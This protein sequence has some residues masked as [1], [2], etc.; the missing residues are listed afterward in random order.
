MGG[1]NSHSRAIREHG[2]GVR[3]R[4]KARWW[5]SIFHRPRWRDNIAGRYSK[6]S[7]IGVASVPRS[8]QFS[9][10][11]PTLR[12]HVTHTKCLSRAVALAFLTCFQVA[13]RSR[14]LSRRAFDDCQIAVPK[15]I[16]LKNRRSI[17]PCGSFP[18]LDFSSLC[19]IST[20]LSSSRVFTFVRTFFQREFKR[21]LE[22]VF[23]LKLN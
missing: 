6:S 1:C 21:S 16:D 17:S 4:K 15:G 19:F 9:D 18:C 8:V 13:N 14:L 5:R 23:V 20:L 2:G 11:F 10:S 12:L 3:A 22:M 7:V